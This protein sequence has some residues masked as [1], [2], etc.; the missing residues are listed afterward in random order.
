ML[1]YRAVVAKGQDVAMNLTMLKKMWELGIKDLT[2]KLTTTTTTTTSNGRL[3]QGLLYCSLYSS[4]S[5]D[6]LSDLWEI[7]AHRADRFKASFILEHRSACW[8]DVEPSINKVIKSLPHSTFIDPGIR[9]CGRRLRE[10]TLCNRVLDS[11]RHLSFSRYPKRKTKFAKRSTFQG[12]TESP[13]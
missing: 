9:L 2:T 7:M 4:N 3:S 10:N 1:L 12:S 8:F 13:E 6:G 11:H 5:V